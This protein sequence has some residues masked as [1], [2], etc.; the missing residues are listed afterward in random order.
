MVS[1]ECAHTI[2]YYNIITHYSLTH[3]S[4]FSVL[5]FCFIRYGILIYGIASA[6]AIYVLL[7]YMATYITTLYYTYYNINMAL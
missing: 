5:F 4:L 3:S 6:N 1:G 2:I 7:D